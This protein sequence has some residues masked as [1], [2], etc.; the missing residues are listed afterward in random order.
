[1]FC[2]GCNKFN[3]LGIAND[4]TE[5][6]DINLFIPREIKGFD[7]ENKIKKILPG[8][9]HSLFVCEKDLFFTGDISKGAI[10]IKKE[11]ISEDWK[12]KNNVIK[13]TKITEYLPIDFSLIKTFYC[14]WHNSFFLTSKF[15]L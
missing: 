1:M 6:N 14:S 2:F 10:G 8:F 4:L 13:L 7:R 5:L 3:H 9:K 11:F 12:I 15:N